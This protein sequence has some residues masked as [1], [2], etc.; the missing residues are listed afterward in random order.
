MDGLV[1]PDRIGLL[2][3]DQDYTV[4]RSRSRWRQADAVGGT[5]RLVPRP[6]RS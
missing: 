2:V 3:R 1:P 5:A 4:K 6:L